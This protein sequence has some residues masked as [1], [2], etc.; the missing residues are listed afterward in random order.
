MSCP[1]ISDQ[2]MIAVVPEAS[3]NDSRWARNHLYDFVGI[4]EDR[5]SDPPPEPLQAHLPVWALV[6]NPG[7][8]DEEVRH[9]IDRE[10]SKELQ[11]SYLVEHAE[12][13]R[14]RAKAVGERFPNRSARLGLRND[15]QGHI[16]LLS[17]RYRG[18]E[19][20]A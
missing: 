7:F 17:R 11:S 19:P 14:R 13:T 3:E 8:S 10:Y 16:V 4:H 5:E 1:T 12:M 18:G 9:W 15:L 6:Q 20:L 2:E